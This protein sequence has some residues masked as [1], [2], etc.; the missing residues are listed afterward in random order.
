[1]P[2]HYVSVL[3][4]IKARLSERVDVLYAEGCKITQG[5]SWQ[6]D[7]VLPSDPEEDGRQI[8]EALEVAHRA[9]RLATKQG[10]PNLVAVLQAH[11]ASY[12]AHR[13]VRQEPPGNEAD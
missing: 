6:Q 2:K 5:G 1:M 7:E 12:E 9:V 3:D 10:S 11:I 8:A 4:G 13:P